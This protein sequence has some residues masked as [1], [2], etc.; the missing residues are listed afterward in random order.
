MSA[1]GVLADLEP[2]PIIVIG[3]PFLSSSFPG[4]PGS[5]RSVVSSAAAGKASLRMS[6]AYFWAYWSA[7]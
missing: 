4:R 2:V 6:G 7:L 3:L 1:R 5:A